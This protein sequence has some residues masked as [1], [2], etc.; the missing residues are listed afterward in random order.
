MIFLINIE[1]ENIYIKLH[2][3]T[4]KNLPNI[5]K[6]FILDVEVNIYPE[7]NFSRIIRHISLNYES[8]NKSKPMFLFLYIY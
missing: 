4:I 2:D 5:F 7:G 3:T 6:K 1:D 8:K